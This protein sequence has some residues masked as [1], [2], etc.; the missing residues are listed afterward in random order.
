M[1]V[2]ADR[3]MRNVAWLTGSTG[4]VGLCAV[5]TLALN[6][7]GLGTADF[8]TLSL[9]QAYAA[10][11]AGFTS[12]ESWQAV[13]RLGVRMPKRLDTTIASG[14]VLDATVAFFAGV[15]AI[16][17]IWVAGEAFGISEPQQRL[18]SIYALSLFAGVAGTPKGFFRLR[19]DFRTLA[20]N[21]S[22]LAVAM[23]IASAVLWGVEADL[24]AYVITFGAI[25]ATYN[26]TLV[27][28]MLSVLRTDGKKLSFS[29]CKA[30]RRRHLKMMMVISAGNSVLASLHS[31]KRHIAIFLVGYLLGEAAAGIYSM[32]SR[33][34]TSISRFAALM[35]QILFPEVLKAAAD[36]APWMLRRAIYKA[37][38]LG[39]A[40]ALFL[41]TI[42]AVASEWIVQLVGG[43]DYSSAA[44]IFSVLLAA[45][46]IG[47]AGIHFNP[48]IQ[49]NQGTGPLVYFSFVSFSIFA[50]VG[51][52]LSYQFGMLGFASGVL[53]GSISLYLMM[54][55]RV[56]ANLRQDGKCRWD[57]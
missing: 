14:L 9:I 39:G 13:V 10:L 34:V 25:S 6:A 40:L 36:F 28:R 52:T 1:G 37:T 47:L 32:A 19:Q 54:A 57:R 17:G 33:L 3:I 18:A 46:C 4:L 27:V 43:R 51:T 15:L 11:V 16:G 7:R 50:V 30:P 44:S 35:N 41:T 8:G 2:I 56:L 55:A 42:G 48:V 23:L 26:L 22:A 38:L 20:G 53:A 24:T 21:Q 31:S 5:G 49:Q 12:L 45:E 29:F